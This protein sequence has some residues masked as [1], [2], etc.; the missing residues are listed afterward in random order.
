MFLAPALGHVDQVVL[1]Q[2]GGALQDRGGD[3]DGIARQRPQQAPGRDGMGRDLFGQFDADLFL[4]LAGELGHDVVE[5]G[6]FRLVLVVDAGEEQVGHLAQQFPPPFA[7][8]F[9]GQVDEVS[10]LGHG[11]WQ[12]L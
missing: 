1:G 9:L 3:G 11:L 8:R 6:G 5:E 7:G 12:G 4:H 2:G 10:K